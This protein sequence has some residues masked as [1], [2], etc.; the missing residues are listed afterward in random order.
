MLNPSQIGAWTLRVLGI[1]LV[2]IAL[3]SSLDQQMLIQAREWGVFSQACVIAGEASL[4]TWF[5]G[6]AIRK[7]KPMPSG[8]GQAGI[9]LLLAG[10]LLALLLFLGDLTAR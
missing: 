2:L 8:L 9:G 4:A 7:R 1:I 10:S 5:L 3:Q 6:T